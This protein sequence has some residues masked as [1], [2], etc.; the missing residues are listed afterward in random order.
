M[1]VL[2]EY[3]KYLKEKRTYMKEPNY[4][5]GNIKHEIGIFEREHVNQL[6]IRMLFHE[7]HGSR[8]TVLGRAGR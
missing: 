8:G 1:Y 6:T 5:E 2:L 7:V 3:R 4:E